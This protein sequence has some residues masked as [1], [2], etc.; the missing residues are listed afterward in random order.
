M[1]RIIIKY[2]K[3]FNYLFDKILHILSS[4]N[5]HMLMYVPTYTYLYLKAKPTLF[6]CDFY[7][8]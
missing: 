5:L 6:L 2:F 1:K 4:M 3:A 7:I 8:Y